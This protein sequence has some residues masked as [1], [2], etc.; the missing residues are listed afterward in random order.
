M[1]HNTSSAFL[2]SCCACSH[3]ITRDLTPS[4]Q[5]CPCLPLTCTTS[6]HSPPPHHRL[7]PLR[8][9]QSRTLTL[10]LCSLTSPPLIRRRLLLQLTRHLPLPRPEPWTVP[11][12]ESLSPPHHHTPPPPLPTPH[13]CTTTPPTA[14]PP[15]LP[16]ILHKCLL[17]M[18]V[19]VH[20]HAA[21]Y[22]CN[23]VTSTADIYKSSV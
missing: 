23:L 21:R 6:P 12:P 7:L 10:T 16:G 3:I 2:A 20:V 11:H 15:P 4:H 19:H 13:L 1:T 9:P 18:L 14:P 5:Y 8:S 17:R 22:S